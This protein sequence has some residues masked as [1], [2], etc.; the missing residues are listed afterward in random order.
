MTAPAFG[1]AELHGG[2]S[3]VTLVPA[4]GGK[5]SEIHL[6]GR[7]WLWHNPRM[8]FA[9]PQEGASYVRTAD[10]G[11]FDECFPTVA[12]C[13][14]PTWVKGA[15]DVELP[16]HGE[17]WSQEPTIVIETVDAGHRATCT[18]S[19]TR[20]PYRFTREVTVRPDGAIAFAYAV[21]NTGP[22]RLPFVWSSHPLFPLTSETRIVLPEGARTRVWSQHGADF[23]GPLAE[24]RWPRMR[25]SGTMADMSNPARALSQPYACKLFVELPPTGTVLAIHEGSAR[26][27]ITLDG[28]EVPQ[29]GLWINHGGWSPFASSR[30]F[31]PWKKPK[32]YFN[33]AIEPCIGAPDSLA[34]ALGAWDSA[35]W[36][37]PRSSTRWSMTWRGTVAP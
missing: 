24:Q 18:W 12:E 22:N 11:G 17:L 21:E 23:G 16:D 5:L 25:A 7:Q 35:H 31:L 6:A 8:P 34:E 15:G 14:L 13:R 4:L 32:P 9:L 37:E 36:I 20:L 3:S 30:P 33:F 26:L 2:E 29:V 27:E 19:G 1:F 28:A 10:S